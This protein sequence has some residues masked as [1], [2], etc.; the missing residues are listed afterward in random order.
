MTD[1]TPTGIYFDTKK[2]PFDI[3]IDNNRKNLNYLRMFGILISRITVD[4]K[5]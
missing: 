2:K 3:K 4:I 5:L 1:R